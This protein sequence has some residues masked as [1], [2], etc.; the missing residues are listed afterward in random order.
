MADGFD[1]FNLRDTS[2][3]GVPERCEACGGGLRYTGLGEYKCERCGALTY[4]NYGKVRSYIEKNP[5]ATAIEVSK[6]TGVTKSAIK[7]LLDN[8]RI[9]RRPYH[10]DSGD[11]DFV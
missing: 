8:D 5:G 10:K 1:V 4:D 9:Q 3:D 2:D 6:A 11:D 7:R